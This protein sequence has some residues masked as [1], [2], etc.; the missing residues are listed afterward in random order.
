MPDRANRLLTSG[1][2]DER[3]EPIVT[4]TRL[5]PDG[6]AGED[7]VEPHFT[8]VRVDR[9]GRRLAAGEPDRVE[10]LPLVEAP[11]SEISL[12][13][14]AGV[15]AGEVREVRTSRGPRIVALA[16]VFAIVAGAGVLA[17]TFSGIIGGGGE[18]QREVAAVAAAA[19]EAS[20]AEPTVA[21]S[22]LPAVPTSAGGVRVVTTDRIPD[23]TAALAPSA[24]ADPAAGGA[25]PSG[26]AAAWGE[27]ALSAEPPG[28]IIETPPA[29]RLRPATASFNPPQTGEQPIFAATPA[30]A[31]GQP[32]GQSAEQPSGGSDLDS[33]LA[34]VD[35]ILEARRSAPGDVYGTGDYTGTGDEDFYGVEMAAPQ[36]LPYPVLPPANAAQPVYPAD[37]FAAPQAYPP[38]A[39]YGQQAYPTSP[40]YP[41][42]VYGPPIPPNYDPYDPY[43][44]G[45][46]VAD[47]APP[48]NGPWW[49]PRRRT[50]VVPNAPVPP[51][52]VPGGVW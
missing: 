21:D 37:P 6:G 26:Q 10:A 30:P 15:T 39:P 42:E 20:V 46:D 40:V 11:P 32:S 3:A 18:P 36:P 35:R 5:P 14:L 28:R 13:P 34:N 8:A 16:G 12:D 27:A 38:P 45:V 24:A 19:P 9:H 44:Y 50:V 33:A 25:A 1:G 7:R 51:A 29:P 2:G 23:D 52:D 4:Y 49:L 48:Q 43:G 31:F 22:L 41:G 17:A 47:T